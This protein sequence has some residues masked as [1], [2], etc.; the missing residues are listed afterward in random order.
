MGVFVVRAG[1]DD[2]GA[3]PQDFYATLRDVTKYRTEYLNAGGG[4]NSLDLLF[5]GGAQQC[6]HLGCPE[7]DRWFSSV[8]IVEVPSSWNKTTFR[9]WFTAQG[10]SSL[11]SVVGLDSIEIRC[12]QDTGGGEPPSGDY[13]LVAVFVGVGLVV[14]I[15]CAA[16]GYAC[17][18]GTKKLSRPTAASG[19]DVVHHAKDKSA[20]AADAGDL[21]LPVA[22][23]V[24]VAPHN[25]GLPAVE[26][27]PVATYAS[28]ASSGGPTGAAVNT[29]V[30][31]AQFLKDHGLKEYTPKLFELGFDSLVALRYAQEED[32]KPLMKVGH[33]RMFMAAIKKL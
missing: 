16:L 15:V 22:T 28:G 29:K 11:Y 24:V 2:E 19:A 26:A 20:S 33:L 23:P 9:V 12:G 7:Y 13:T 4:E 27:V 18:S 21:E 25:P 30:E 14:L 8:N 17:R 6:A 32:A 10:G 31:A 1:D 5:E 3:N